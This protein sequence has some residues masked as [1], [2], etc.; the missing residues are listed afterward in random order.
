MPMLTGFAMPNT[1]S[2]EFNRKMNNLLSSLDHAIPL[3]E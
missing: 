3:K 2:M 1:G